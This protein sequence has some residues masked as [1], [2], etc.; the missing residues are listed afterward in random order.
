MFGS[1]KRA[2]FINLLEKSWEVVPIDDKVLENHL[3][4]KGLSN[5]FLLLLTEPR[6]NPLSPEAPIVFATGPLNIPGYPGGAR[7]VVSFKSPLTGS[8]YESYAGG[9]LPLS[10]RGAGYDV[11][12]IRGALEKWGVVI[13][14]GDK[15][16]FMDAEEL[17]GKN[18]GETEEFLKRKL[19]KDFSI[20]SIGPAGERMIPFSSAIHNFT[21][22]FGRAG[23]GA[24]MGSKKLKAVCIRGKSFPK[25]KNPEALREIMKKNAKLIAGSDYGKRLK[26]FGTGSSMEEMNEKG[27][28]PTKYYMMTSFSEIEKVT[29]RFMRKTGI[30]VGKNACPFCPAGCIKVVE[31]PELGVER[32]W[33]GPEY[34][35]LVSFGPLIMNSDVR[36]IAFAHKLCNSTGLDT[37]T[38]GSLVGMVF[39]AFEAGKLKTSDV[40]FEARWGDADAAVK[41]LL[42]M[43]NG[44]GIG[45]VLARGSREAGKL[46][47]LDDPV[48]VK[49]LEIPYQEVRGNAGM[50]LSY[51]TSYRG[52][53]HT[54]GFRDTFHTEEN[55]SPELGIEEALNNFKIE[56]KAP[57]VVKGENFRSFVNSLVLCFL[58]VLISGS[59]R[60]IHTTLEAVSHATGLSVDIELAMEI[61]ER[62]YMLGRI[63]MLREGID[64]K[65]DKLPERFFRPSID[66]RFIDKGKF[67]KELKAY[68]KERGFDENGKPLK[69]KLEKL[70]LSSFKSTITSF[71]CKMK[72]GN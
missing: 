44:S 4:G 8:I 52:A 63:F 68:Y 34:E 70:G 46:L 48:H 54:E 39:E 12:V 53:V 22:A 9:T 36:K 45:P 31:V 71:T 59:T 18:T 47:D 25:V 23:L 40:G 16:V 27:L 1:W 33:G 20:V 60:N 72:T 2:L 55:S 41:L 38:S 26:E 58:V 7:C 65:E 51:A 19:G 5:L 67:E 57:Y 32:T 42:S 13:V 37:I 61:G 15:T 14:D 3:G 17:R 49:G 69:K 24:V 21:R 11:V 10:I 29:P 50:A 62:N 28:I 30:M 6:Y 64:P 43:I 35:T 56:G 66:G